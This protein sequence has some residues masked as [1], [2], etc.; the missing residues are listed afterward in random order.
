[1]AVHEDVCGREVE[2]IDGILSDLESGAMLAVHE[3]ASEVVGGRGDEVGMFEVD[4][5]SDLG[6][7]FVHEDASDGAEG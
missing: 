5:G 7:T 4:S 2:V 1:M 3:D 6:T